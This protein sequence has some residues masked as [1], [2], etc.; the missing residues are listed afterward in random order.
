[1]PIVT[2]TVES[3]HEAL[4]GRAAA[5]LVESVAAALACPPADVWAQVV[6]A[7]A[8]RQ[9]VAHPQPPACPIVIVRGRAR[10]G[11]AVGR[12]LGAAA[13][14]LHRALGVAVDDV[15]VQWVEVAEGR[16]FAGGAL[17]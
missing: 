10:D 2:A 12:A 15:W 14:A 13:G 1:M 8:V 5:A 7:A 3:R 9:G 17:R 11:E 6:C 16:V 4:A